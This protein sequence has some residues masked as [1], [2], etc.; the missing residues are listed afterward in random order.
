[1]LCITNI[2]SWLEQQ[3]L[4]KIFGIFISADYNLFSVIEIKVIDTYHFMGKGVKVIKLGALE[5]IPSVFSGNNIPLINF[6]GSFIEH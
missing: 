2:V 6:E 1:M 4:L 3:E 5:I